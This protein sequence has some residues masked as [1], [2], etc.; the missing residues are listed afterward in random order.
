MKKCYLIPVLLMVLGFSAQAQLAVF[1]DDYAAGV[2]FVAF[3][4]SNNSLSIDAANARTG[5]A[6]T[7]SLKVDVP[8]GGYTGGA[9]A[10][11]TPTNLSTY[12]AVSF[13]TK[14]S[15]TVTLN[16]AGLGN[17]GVAAPFQTE[18]GGIAVT[19]AWVKVIIPI[20]DAAKLT[21]ADGLFHFAEGAD[22]G[23]YTLWIDDVQY[24]NLG[25][26]VIG[27]AVPQMDNQ[28][29]TKNVGGTFTITGTKATVPVNSTNLNLTFVPAYLTLTS[30]P[31]GNVTF[32]ATGLCTAAAAG[33]TTVT[34][35][36]GA[37]NVS[38]TINV[39]IVD[40]PS[41]P[42][43]QAPAPPTRAAADVIS[44]YSG[45]Y[46]PELAGTNWNPFWGQTTIATE[47]MIEGN[48]TRKYAGLTYQG[49]EFAAAVNASAM[50]HLHMDV[51]TPDATAFEVFLINAGGVEQAVKVT[52]TLST[53]NRVDID[54]S[55]YPTVNKGA[56]IQFK[57]VGTPWGSNTVFVDN[58][59]FYK[60]AA[61]SP[62]T[63][64]PTPPTRASDKVISLFSAAYTN[65]QNIDW[66]PN[67]GQ[68]TAVSEITVQGDVIRK[69]ATLNYQ[70]VTFAAPLNLSGMNKLHFDI[71]TTN[72]TAFEMFLINPG[73]VEKAVSVAPTFGE[74]KSVDINL[75]EYSGVVA[76]N[77]VFQLKLVGTPF[78]GSTV[79]LDNIYFYN[80]ATL[81]VKLTS[82]TAARKDNGV[83]L[84]WNTATESNNKGFAVER[85]RDG[86]SWSEI[87]FVKAAGSSTLGAAY[88][89]TDVNPL[90]AINYY[91]LK[92]VDND[93]KSNYSAVKA[94][95]MGTEANSILVYPNPTKGRVNIYTG[96]LNGKNTYSLISVDGKL[97]KS[98]L[99]AS[100]NAILTLDLSTLAPGTY[101]VKLAGEGINSSRK[102]VIN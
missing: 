68:S 49:V 36:L 102:L 98:G 38:G 72:C 65:V 77:N 28:T 69:Y 3:G 89:S 84:Q 10:S 1:S 86:L 58:M 74:W 76:L 9:L 33:A 66:N 12:N 17:N 80:D 6:G 24:E 96:E 94:V 75:S 19:T 41:S 48:A 8:A 20:P 44:L 30:T 87:S 71:W 88:N 60:A 85:S 79:F 43:T 46:T 32:D 59:Y 15:K 99:I 18:L 4:G 35:K 2:S 63:A 39:T 62:T 50:T 47:V 40:A 61:T 93:G 14:A 82:F 90:K 101:W 11:A 42:P 22:E 92:Q 52:P 81:P 97:L 7:K 55:A 5:S 25:G 21:A 67:W 51:W 54:L 16:V 37:V 100:G 83:V 73:P 57:F 27:T 91:R 70:G 56:V 26:G 13:W 45:A 31:A 78:G 95:N 34:A 23:A 53:W 64:A 29:I